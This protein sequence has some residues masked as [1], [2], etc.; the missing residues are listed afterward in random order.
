MKHN[1]WVVLGTLFLILVMIVGCAPARTA[2]KVA[3]QLNVERDAGRAAA[4]P[5][6]APAQPVAEAASSAYGGGSSGT[7]DQQ[8]NVGE[9][10]II[11]TVEMSVVVEDTDKAFDQLQALIKEYQGYVSDSRRWYEGEQPLANVTI[12]V[13]AASLSEALAKIRALAIRVES[14]N[15]SGQDVTEEYTDVQ[16][17]LRNLETT[18]KELLLLETQVRESRGKAEDILA[19]H[20]EIVSIRGQIESLKGRQQYLERMT[21]LATIHLTIRPKAMPQPLVQSE[22]WNPLITINRALRNFVSVVQVLVDIL[23]YLL[24]FSPIILVPLFIL[25][26]LVRLIRRGKKSKKDEPTPQS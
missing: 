19:V 15:A 23:L 10:M 12:R 5:P 20:R 16:A 26:L 24:V 3:S 2:S 1:K 25:W 21:A 18:E 7:A 6:A 4:T 11:S 8:V 14:E 13:P 22:T 17:R 9:R